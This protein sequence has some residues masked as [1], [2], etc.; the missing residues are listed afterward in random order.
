MYVQV[1]LVAR[2][3]SKTNTTGH[4]SM[5]SR[6]EY[7]HHLKSPCTSRSL[8][9]SRTQDLPNLRRALRCSFCFR[10]ALKRVGLCPQSRCARRGRSR[11]KSWAQ[12]CCCIV[13]SRRQPCPRLWPGRRRA[14]ARAGPLLLH[15]RLQE[16]QGVLRWRQQYQCRQQLHKDRETSTVLCKYHQQ[17][18]DDIQCSHR[19][20]HYTQTDE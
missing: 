10:H 5:E 17:Q 4:A 16:R 14:G 11:S 15:F 19:C 8:Q 2:L 20:W 18:T 6:S 1:Y 12:L 9:K 3:R 13:W 7:Y